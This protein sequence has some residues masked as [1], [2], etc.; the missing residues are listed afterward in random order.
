MAPG[1]S[2]VHAPGRQGIKPHWALCWWYNARGRSNWSWDLSGAHRSYQRADAYAYI[3]AL[4]H[5]I[6]QVHRGLQLVSVFVRCKYVIQ[7]H[8]HLSTHKCPGAYYHTNALRF[9]IGIGIRAMPICHPNALVRIDTK[10][11]RCT[12]SHKCTEIYNWYRYSCGENMSYKYTGVYRHI[13][14]LV[15]SIT[16]IH[17]DL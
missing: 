16:Q 6:T 4:V 3:N 12:V 8:R 9:V 14:A 11:P 7:M 10:T 1:Q 2:K 5:R 13:N 15:H 17:R